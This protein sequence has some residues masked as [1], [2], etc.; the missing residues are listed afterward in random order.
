MF[1]SVSC[2]RSRIPECRAKIVKEFPL[3]LVRLLLT[4]LNDDFDVIITFIY[5]E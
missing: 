2:T 5:L 4:A 3:A 1:L